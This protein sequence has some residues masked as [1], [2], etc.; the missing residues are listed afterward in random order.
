MR[1][2]RAAYQTVAE[3][4]GELESLFIGA[5][6]HGLRRTEPMSK[7]KAVEIA[8]RV[9]GLDKG[10][11]EHEIGPNTI[12]VI[13]RV[14]LALTQAPARGQAAGMGVGELPAE[15]GGDAL[16]QHAGTDSDPGGR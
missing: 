4:R 10:I 13:E 7:D 2:A 3:A 12:A 5:L 14:G 11:G 9:L 15:P 6:Q 8:G 16:P 1:E